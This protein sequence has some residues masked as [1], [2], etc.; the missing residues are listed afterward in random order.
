MQSPTA[1]EAR[2]MWSWSAIVAGTLTSLIVQVL[3]TMLG[4]GVGLIATDAPTANNAPAT[5]SAAA[6][7]WFIASGIFSAF[8]GGAVAGA[9]S[10]SY[11]DRGRSA[12][13]LATWALTSLI[14]VGVTML[15]AGGAATVAGQL[16]GPS[17][18]TSTRLQT[19]TTRREANVPAPTQA[20]IEAARKAAATAMFVSFI[21]LVLGAVFAFVGGRWSDE[22]RDHFTDDDLRRS[23]TVTGDMPPRRY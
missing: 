4:L 15:T 18:T 8:V 10:P 2:V 21:G 14:V 17:V 12:H 16:A 11:T 22:I 20:Q 19:M 6:A 13:A 1:S 3:L 7:L 9:L 5:V 23:D